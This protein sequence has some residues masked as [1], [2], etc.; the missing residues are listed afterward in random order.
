MRPGL[1]A[2]QN[3]KR[4][5]PWI[6]L[7]IFLIYAAA[8]M[9]PPARTRAGYDL[10]GF[11]RLPVRVNARVQ[12][13]DSAARVGLLQIR[14]TVTVPSEDGKAWQI[15]KH[16]L[17]ATEW[18]LELLTKPDAA[19]ERRIFPVREE[20]LLLA[21]HLDRAAAGGPSY[22]AFTQLQPRLEELGKQ[23][24]R[25]N[26][27]K[28]TDRAAW[29]KECLALRNAV[30]IYERLKNSLQPNSFLQQEA[31]GKPI[32]YDADALLTQY[33]IDLR[34]GIS[35]AVSR[36]HGK[37]QALDAVTEQRMQSF[38]RPYLA[39]SRSAMLSI[40][41]PTDAA[42][43]DRWQN[44]GVSIIESAR[45]GQV[46]APL[47]HFAAMS[48]A[49]A[50]GKPDK[51][52]DHVTKYRLWLLARQLAPEVSRARYEFSYHAFQPFLR[53]LAVYLVAVGLLCVALWKRS[54]GLAR[55]GFMLTLLAFALHTAGLLFEMMLEGRPP[56]TNVYVLIISA[57]W[58]AVLVA[59]AV[60]RRVRNG[61]GTTFAALAG[62]ATLG[63]AHSLA[64]GGATELLRAVLNVSFWLACAALALAL[65][66]GCD[67]GPSGRHHRTHPSGSRRRA[68]G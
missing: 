21:L 62:V 46:G 53:A 15:W 29:E 57:G 17:G 30:V 41:P 36:E 9:L 54:A 59:G 48:S 1:V 22:F 27:V 31:R 37:G 68:L 6:I 26:R 3:V 43:R 33:Q 39:V 49:F 40:I 19:D 7:S 42:A 66:A 10:T 35:A 61:W 44:P 50:Q 25:I 47:A 65:Y 24:F 52:N 12:P 8:A 55:S 67:A 14:G 4:F 5:G 38:A 45:T 63:L 64:P 58:G 34:A 11:G 2:R 60:E 28:A 23:A 51:F 16:D 13:M 20:A 56:I 18:L 32:A